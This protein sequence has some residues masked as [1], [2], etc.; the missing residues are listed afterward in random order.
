MDCVVLGNFATFA[1]QREYTPYLTVPAIRLLSRLFGHLSISI[2]L[3]T[4]LF[5]T[6][7]LR[8]VHADHSNQATEHALY[9]NLSSSRGFG[10]PWKRC[11]WLQ[12]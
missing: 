3:H 2:R 8:T 4:L 6:R 11:A 12:L 1:F 10:R 7:L 5:L 9:D